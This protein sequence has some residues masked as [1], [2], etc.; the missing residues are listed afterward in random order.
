[1]PNM[2][3]LVKSLARFVSHFGKTIITG[4]A[5][6]VN[7]PVYAAVSRA[8]WCRVVGEGA[9]VMGYG[10]WGTGHGGTGYWAWWYRGIA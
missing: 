2:Q 5:W 6:C 7:G 9:G 1:M 10:A 8:W 3:T 4:R